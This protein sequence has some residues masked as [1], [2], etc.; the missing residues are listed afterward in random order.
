MRATT[1]DRI[2]TML[3]NKLIYNCVFIYSNSVRR[4]EALKEASDEKKKN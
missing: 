2:F 1:L 3:Y 4:G